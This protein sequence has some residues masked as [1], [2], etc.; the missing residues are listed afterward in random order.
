VSKVLQTLQGLLSPN[1]A[2]D[3]N[4]REVYHCGSRRNHTCQNT[5]RFSKN[6]RSNSFSIM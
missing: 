6:K 1:L 2:Q 5:L 4:G 3:L